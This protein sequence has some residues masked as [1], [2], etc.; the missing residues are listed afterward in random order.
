MYGTRDAAQNWAN[1]YAEMLKGI[2]FTQGLAFPC[3]FH[4][5]L[6]GVT[7]FV[8]GDDYVSVAMP[9]RLTWLND[10]LE[11]KY[12]IKTQWLGPGKGHQREVKIVN[13]IIGWDN[14]KGIVYEADPRH[15]EIIVD[16]LKLKD[17]KAVATPGAKEEC[18][19]T[20]DCTQALDE[21]QASMYRAI[22][23]RC[24]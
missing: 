24:N 2:G 7:I 15:I 22:A 4:H 3:V 8:H 12:K 9:K 20:Y 10:Q 21:Q 11:L 19:I 23:A 14:Q 1:E 17:A 6:R 16:Q 18:T 13:R 5:K